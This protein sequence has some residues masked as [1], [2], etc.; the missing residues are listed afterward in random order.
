MKKFLYV[1]LV[2]SIVCGCVFAFAGCGN[3]DKYNKELI[4]NG[5]FES[6]ASYWREET[7]KDITTDGTL[8]VISYGGESKENY[9]TITNGSAAGNYVKLY[10]KVEVNRNA[11]YK[12]T[13]RIKN[14]T[15]KQGSGSE[16]I[17]GAGIQIVESGDILSQYADVT[18]GWV[19]LTLYVKPKNTDTLTVALIFGNADTYTV[20]TVA[21]DNISLTRIKA[22]DVPSDADVVS[23]FKIREPQYKL[24]TS[25]ATAL[26][27][28]LAIFSV[29]VIVGFY[30]AYRKFMSDDK[31]IFAKPW[32]TAA[33]IALVA[34]TIRLILAG[35][36]FDGGNAAYTLASVREMVQHGGSRVIFNHTDLTPFQAY[37]YWVCGKIVY[38]WTSLGAVNVMV[39]LFPIICEGITVA[40]IYFFGKKYLTDKQAAL[41]AALYAILPVSVIA[42]SGYSV[43]IPVLTALLLFTFYALIEKDFISLLIGS[44]VLCLWSSI[45]I[46]VLPFIV[47]YEIYIMI[48]TKDKKTICTLC[49]GWFASFWLFILLSAPAVKG[50]FVQG[51][52]MY[53]FKSYYLLMFNKQMCVSNAFNL[54][55]L[56]G[57][58]GG[59][60]NN[61]AFALNIVFSLILIVYCVSLY[62][63]NYNRAEMTLIAGFFLTVMAVFSLNMNETALIFGL[64]MLLMYIIV[65]GEIRL[66]WVFGMLSFMAFM[67]M[68]I[69]LDY[70]GFIGPEFKQIFF[71]KGD[72]GYAIANVISACT[73]LYYGW[74]VY[75]ITTNGKLKYIQPLKSKSSDLSKVPAKQ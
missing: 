11:V 25:G 1:L 28:C 44:L 58:N 59:S 74:V 34:I 13:A 39:N 50:M 8:N 27:V 37:Y 60:V 19:D 57:L 45:G 52:I 29:L 22:G 16:N 12:L 73:V 20:G 6:N 62:F 69:V 56:F 32:I 66:F 31:P 7:A 3:K 15:I 30:F 18:D 26:V 2:I 72:A 51:H 49:A 70:T 43:E 75:D 71:N 23:I 36:L 9:I 42:G 21:F 40:L 68:G 47:A 41:F 54:Y 24:S 53:V 5:S 33:L 38:N 55:A 48:K 35:T 4:E 64:I 61:A 46:Y 14:E 65:T 63:K 10:Q 17:A 67:N